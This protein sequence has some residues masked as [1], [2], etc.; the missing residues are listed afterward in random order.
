[1]AGRA[2]A[3]SLLRSL[4]RISLRHA[5]CCCSIKNMLTSNDS[6]CSPAKQRRAG[7]VWAPALQARAE[8]RRR[9]SCG[10]RRS[11]RSPGRSATRSRPCAPSPPPGARIPAP[12]D[13]RPLICTSRTLPQSRARYAD[14]Q[15]RLREETL[16]RKTAQDATFRA[17]LCSKELERSR[18]RVLSLRAAPGNGSH[19][20]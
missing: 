6:A 2:S 7:C 13:R 9:L 17:R 12:E 18:F 4:L 10:T 16:K 15:R 5:H 14:K 8:R 1:M 19:Q 20:V 11:Q 3:R